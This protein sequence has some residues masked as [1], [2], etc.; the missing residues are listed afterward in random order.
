MAPNEVGSTRNKLAPN[1][2]APNEVGST[3]NELAP[4]ELAPDRPE[5]DPLTPRHFL[6][7]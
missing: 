4:N 3:R 2:L 1:E 6:T 5:P 7:T